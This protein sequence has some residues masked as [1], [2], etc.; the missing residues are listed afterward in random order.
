MAANAQKAVPCPPASTAGT[1]ASMKANRRMDTKPEIAL[2]SA[3]HRRGFRFRKDLPVRFADRLVRPDIVFTKARVAVF[4]D[5]C[6]WHCCPEHG[7][8][9]ATNQDYWEPKLDKNVARDQRVNAGLKRAGWTVLRFWEH[10]PVERAVMSIGAAVLER[11]GSSRLSA[12]TVGR[13]S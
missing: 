10:V 12:G 7:S 3:L 11:S 1:Q 5:G 13:E 4:V 2:R 6:F 9:P 8:R